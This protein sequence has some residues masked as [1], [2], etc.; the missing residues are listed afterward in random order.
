M[1]LGK[2]NVMKIFFC[3]LALTLFAFSRLSYADWSVGVN[4]G[5]PG[6]HHDDRHFYR[7]HDHPRYGLHIGFLP[8]GYF[9]I[10]AGGTRYYYYDGLYYTYAGYGDYVL[11]APP[12]GAYVSV[13][14]SD[15]QPVFINGVTY[16]T[17]NGVY[18]I[19]TRH[20]GYQVVA[21]PVVYAQPAQ[22]VVAQPVTVVTAPAPA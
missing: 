15:F 19:L 3:V 20:H 12:V 6:Y 16:Y 13:I 18:Y 22:V 14:P 2:V 7:W 21:A 1:M 10:W 5:G 9:T 11:V 8:D 4:F 17:N